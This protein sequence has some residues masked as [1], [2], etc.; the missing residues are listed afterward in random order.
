[1]KNATTRAVRML[2]TMIAMQRRARLSA[3]LSEYGRIDAEIAGMV[4]RVEELR[5]R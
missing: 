3:P 2:E 5:G 1:M 4:A